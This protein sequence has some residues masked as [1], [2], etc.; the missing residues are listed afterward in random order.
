MVGGRSTFLRSTTIQTSSVLS[1]VT[2]VLVSEL[3]WIVTNDI[4]LVEH[5]TYKYSSHSYHSLRKALEHMVEHFKK[6]F[7]YEMNLELLDGKKKT[8]EEFLQQLQQVSWTIISWVSQEPLVECLK[9]LSFWPLCHSVMWNF[10]NY[11]SNPILMSWCKSHWTAAGHW[12]SAIQSACPREWCDLVHSPIKHGGR[13]HL[14]HHWG[15]Q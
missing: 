10:V 3:N 6:I 9:N 7:N 5:V 2:S 4:G 1:I 8:K 13:W 15:Q 12:R 14:D 11:W